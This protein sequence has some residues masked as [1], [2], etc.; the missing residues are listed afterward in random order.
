M[1]IGIGGSNLGTWA[2]YDA[3]GVSPPATGSPE[4]AEG[5][6]GV[7]RGGVTLNAITVM[8]GG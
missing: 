6:F 8:F 1:V 7:N 4:I 2:V 5:I 3:L